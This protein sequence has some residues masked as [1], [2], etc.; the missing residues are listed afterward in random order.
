MIKGGIPV[1]EY[2]LN[3]LPVNE[4]EKKEFE[5]IAPGAIHVYAGRRTVTPEQLELATVILGWPR[6]EDVKKAVRLKWFQCMW[7][8]TE[9]YEG[10]LPDGAALT[11][12]SGSNRRSVAEHML[13]STLA[14][15]RRLPAYRDSQK[16][17]RW[18]DDG[19]MKTLLDATV[20]VVGRATLALPTPGCAGGWGPIPSA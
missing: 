19:V 17:H 11:S 12:S 4:E 5:A 15:F 18:Q 7:A 14:L 6:S 20:L 1:S 9:E 10:F 16:A 2:I 8:G 3:L 13:A